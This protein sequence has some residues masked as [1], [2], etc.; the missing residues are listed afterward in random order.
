MTLKV[1]FG[2][3]TKLESLSFNDSEYCVKT[4][5]EFHIQSDYHV[6]NLKFT[7]IIFFCLKTLSVPTFSD[8]KKWS[9]VAKP[10]PLPSALTDTTIVALPACTLALAHPTVTFPWPR[11]L[12]GCACHPCGF[13]IVVVNVCRPDVDRYAISGNAYPAI[14]R[15]F[16]VDTMVLFQIPLWRIQW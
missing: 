8:S 13:P 14:L 6:S 5:F 3:C 2:H 10:P 12:T 11:P 4:F 1:I 15:C 9:P 7:T 16:F